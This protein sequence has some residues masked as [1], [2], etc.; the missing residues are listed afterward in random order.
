MTIME[1]TLKEIMEILKDTIDKFPLDKKEY[2]DV[3]HRI[4]FPVMLHLLEQYCRPKD[5]QLNIIINEIIAE[6]KSG[7]N[8]IK[9]L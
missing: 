7:E 9:F 8:V 1:D 2:E 6:H 3:F 4:Y 5:V